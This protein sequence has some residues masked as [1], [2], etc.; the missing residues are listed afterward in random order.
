VKGWSVILLLRP[1]A[2]RLPARKGQKDD[3]HLI[4]RVILPYQPGGRLQRGVTP[5][6]A[7]GPTSPGPGP[8]IEGT[9]RLH[10][11][12]ELSLALYKANTWEIFTLH[13][14]YVRN[15][16]ARHPRFRWFTLK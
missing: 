6:S 1:A 13:L 4:I 14:R 5:F 3:I 12:R 10:A 7:I 15:P 9:G 11:S 8:I 2:S 16:F